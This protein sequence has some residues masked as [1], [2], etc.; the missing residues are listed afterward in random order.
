MTLRLSSSCCGQCSD[1]RRREERAHRLCLL[2]LSILV[3]LGTAVRARGQDISKLIELARQQQHTRAE[4][5][6]V[7]AWVQQQVAQLEGGGVPSQ[8]RATFEPFVGP[9]AAFPVT[10]RFRALLGEKCGELFP[11]VI[12]RSETRQALA[13]AQVLARIPTS[14]T[15]EGLTDCLAQKHQAVRYWGAQGLRLRRPELAAKPADAR[16]ALAAIQTAAAKE[17]N[18][19]ILRQMYAALDYTTPNAP[20]PAALAQDVINTITAVMDARFKTYSAQSTRGAKADADAAVLLARFWQYQRTPPAAKPKLIEYIG[21]LLQAS[22][23]LYV[24]ANAAIAQREDLPL[25]VKACEAQLNAIWRAANP[26]NRDQ[27]LPQVHALIE[28]GPQTALLKLEIYKWI[29][30]SAVPGL[31]NQPP[32]NAAVL[33]EFKFDGR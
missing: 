30:T 27:T 18:A 1:S 2:G 14:S 25:V 7:E 3:G 29:G 26:N 31:L 24:D 22:A 17:T 15:V 20:A 13:M 33:D 32:L 21:N 19:I 23:L 5:R 16:V 12:A 8:F 4:Q 28:T 11:P 9:D 10:P 6:S